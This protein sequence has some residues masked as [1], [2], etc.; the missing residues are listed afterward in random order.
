MK[1]PSMNTAVED[2]LAELESDLM[3][4]RCN[5]RGASKPNMTMINA[6]GS[7]SSPSSSM[8]QDEPMAAWGGNRTFAAVANQI[9][10]LEESGRSG[11]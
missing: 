2:T 3:V 9:G 1:L 8:R 11:R 6:V 4:E 5:S 7:A 10:Q